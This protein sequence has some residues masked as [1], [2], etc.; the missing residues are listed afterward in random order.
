MKKTSL[1][2][3][4]I[5]FLFDLKNQIKT[6]QVKAMLAVNRELILLYF[7]IGKAILEK[8][9]K[10]GWGTKITER[11]SRD[12]RK[13]FPKM[14]GLSHS[15]IRY[16][17]RFA[18]EICLQSLPAVGGEAICQQV[19]PNL[20]S[21]SLMPFFQI[22]WWHNVTLLDQVS[23]QKQRVWYAD[24][25]IVNGWSRSI[26]IKQI[27]SNLYRRQVSANKSHNFDLTLPKAQSELVE[28]LFK[29]QYNFDFLRGD[30]SE[31]ELEDSLVEN[32]T[33]FLLEL[34]RGFSFVGKQY[35]L[36]VGGKD[37]LYPF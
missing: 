8:E 3:T 36:A 5:S 18:E 30:L 14:K 1:K 23:E 13:S 31:K 20:D 15:N 9:I 37:F 27:K 24:Q 26:L 16:M 28:S 29:D 22:P 19:T 21:L 7:K 32:V 35:Q 6:S 25:T 34:G 2:K 17:K 10:E 4:Y 11:I 12:L 33:K